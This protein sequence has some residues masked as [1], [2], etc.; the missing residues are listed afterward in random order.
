MLGDAQWA[1]LK[2]ELEKPAD[3]RLLV[4]SI[5]I[6]PDNHGWEAWDKLP[7]EREKLYSLIEETDANGVV[8][9][10]GDRHQSFLYKDADRGPYPLYEATSSSLNVAFAKDPVSKETDTRMI[11]QGYAFANYG[12]VNIDWEGKTVE[13]VLNDED[14][15]KQ[16]STRFSFAEINA[17][18]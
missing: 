14:G 8:I 17:G 12:E 13:L 15:E 9:L 2:G 7:L 11:G 4:S 6:I 18:E 10:S 3:L 1:W 16:R 5:Q